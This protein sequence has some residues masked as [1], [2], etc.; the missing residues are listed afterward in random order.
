MGPPVTLCYHIVVEVGYEEMTG[1]MRMEERKRGSAPVTRNF[2]RAAS[3]LR[4]MATGGCGSTIV[5][6]TSGAVRAVRGHQSDVAVAPKCT[7]DCQ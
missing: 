7:G 5:P 2:S 1:L 3:N 6:S 4:R